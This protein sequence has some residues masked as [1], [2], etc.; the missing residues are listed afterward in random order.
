MPP[1]AP[2][3]MSSP[4]SAPQYAQG[5][6]PGIRGMATVGDY[7]GRLAKVVPPPKKGKLPKVAPKVNTGNIAANDE[8]Q[9]LIAKYKGNLAKQRE[10]AMNL[11]KQNRGAL[12]MD[13]NTTRDSITKQR[14]TDLS[15][16]RDS[17]AARGI[18]SSSG[19]Y[20]Q[21]GADYETA[22]QDRL[23]NAEKTYQQQLQQQNAAQQEGN[24]EADTEYSEGMAEAAKRKTEA[25][26]VAEKTKKLPQGPQAAPKK[27]PK[28]APRVTKRGLS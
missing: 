20:Q 6:V 1:K 11:Y 28:L 21:A 13:L 25:N 27:Q 8:Y 16:I 4:I 15:D 9:D 12:D 23:K 10:A 2:K 5:S 18:G 22:V 17:Y 24:A 14:G 19:V 26:A 3:G 7:K